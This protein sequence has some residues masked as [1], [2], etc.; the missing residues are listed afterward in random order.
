[1][2]LERLDPESQEWLRHSADHLAR[3]QFA[4][5]Y[6]IGKVVLD[7]GC[8][9]GYGSA[10]LS[11]QGAT[12]V[13]AIDLDSKT[14]HRAKELFGTSQV[15]YSVDN[16]EQ[17]NGV[18]PPYGLICNFENIEHIQNPESFLHR[19]ASVLADDGVLLCSTP[20]RQITAPYVNNKP[21]NPY[22]VQEW[23][24]DDFVVMLSKYFDDVKCLSQVRSSQIDHR[25]RLYA[26]VQ[27]QL[28]ANPF[29]PVKRWLMK[30]RGQAWPSL[31]DLFQEW[32]SDYPI[33]SHAAAGL[34]GSPWCHFAVCRKPKRRDK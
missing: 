28:R 5:Q 15:N 2:A 12:R 27:S 31:N 20:D 16:C 3:Y 13:D 1:M 30:L 24:R 6:S 22:H 26:V 29:Y 21:H 33:V 10:V 14:I 32:P 4:V 17:L 25:K 18:Q 19:A 9:N 8:G 23:Y 34:F 11:D 7:A